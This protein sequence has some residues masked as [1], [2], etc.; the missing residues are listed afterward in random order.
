MFEMIRSD[1]K[2]DFLGM[3]KPFVLASTIAAVISVGLLIK[4]GL[5][6][7]IDFTGGAEVQLQA[8]ASWDIGKLRSEL[9]GAGIKEPHIV[10]IGEPS[11]HEF[12]IKIQAEAEGLNL[13]SSKVN[14]ILKN[15]AGTEPFEVQRVDVVGPAAGADLRQSAFLSIMYA[16]L[17]IVAY[18]AIRF[19]FRYAPGVIR[20]LG[21]DV[22]I[23]LGIWVLLGREFNLTVLASLLTIAGYACNDTI[24]IYDRI[25]D[26]SKEHPDWD[27]AKAINRSISLNL[28][29]TVLTVLCTS[30]VVVSLFIF[31]GTV[32]RDFA[33]PM[34]IG[35]T[36]SVFSTIFVAN[37]MILYMENRRLAKI[38]SASGR[39]LP[40]GHGGARTTAKA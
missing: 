4:P 28:G 5:N 8:P 39:K 35:F 19:D 21:V 6:Y 1:L 34:M 12:L 40:P 14:E 37:P 33:L 26:F 32:L 18:I 13:V 20:A 36:I 3:S 30:F 11:E 15:K 2:V 27:I 17:C 7:G 10:S 16:I 24:V 9:E 38:A 31:G 23:T 29:R 22:I 25:R